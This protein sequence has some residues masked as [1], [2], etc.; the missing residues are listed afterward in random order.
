MSD[1]SVVSGII[2]AD[3]LQQYLDIFQ[4]LVDEGRWHFSEDGI[5]ASVFDP[6]NV[7]MYHDTKLSGRAFESLNAPTGGQATLGLNLQRLDELLGSANDEDLVTFDVDMESRKL[8]LRYRGIEHAMALID[9]DSIRQEPDRPDLELSNH[10]V[11]PADRF[12]EVV[13]NA[14]LTSDHLFVLGERDPAVVAFEARGDVD[15]T[16]IRIG[17]E[18]AVRLDITE[19]NTESVFSLEYM[20]EFAE[21]IPSDADVA[22]SFGDEF[23]MRIEWDAFDGEVVAEGLLAPRIRSD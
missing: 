19:D 1:D 9:P 2:A 3:R 16:E 14:N 22:L 11:I 10:A 7:A 15:E 5:T 4:P 17:A 8:R 23:P 13:E 12:D 6:A 18:G 21:P 20:E